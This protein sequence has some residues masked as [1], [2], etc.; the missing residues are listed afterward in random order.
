MWS[1]FRRASRAWHLSRLAPAGFVAAFSA[2]SFGD[3]ADK[4]ST[5]RVCFAARAT[6]VVARATWE[7]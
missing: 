2:A 1:A 3:S 4:V 6:E 7:R 5:V